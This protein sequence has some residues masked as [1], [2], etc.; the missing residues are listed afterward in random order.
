MLDNKVTVKIRSHYNSDLMFV[1]YYFLRCVFKWQ[2]LFVDVTK[3]EICCNK[4]LLIINLE[5]WKVIYIY[6]YM[7]HCI[8]NH[9]WDM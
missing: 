2:Y 9:H 4:R 7:F 6:I 3:A 5:V 1:K 8:M